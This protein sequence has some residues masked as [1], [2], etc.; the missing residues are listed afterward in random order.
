MNSK[1]HLYASLVKSAIRI[2]ACG[3]TVA[4]GN[5]VVLAF[6]FLGAELLGVAEELFDKR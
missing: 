5:V 2:L 4:T 1:G 6:G 3:I